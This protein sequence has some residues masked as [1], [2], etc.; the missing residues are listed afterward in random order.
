VKLVFEMKRLYTHT[1]KINVICKSTFRASMSNSIEL[2]FFVYTPL[3]ES[4]RN[5]MHSI[6]WTETNGGKQNNEHLEGSLRRLGISGLYYNLVSTELIIMQH[7]LIHL[8]I[9][10]FNCKTINFLF[11]MFMEQR[12]FKKYIFIHHIKLH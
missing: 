12:L 5:V 7:L 8:Y 1:H 11:F 6:S 2:N 4:D 9:F 10:L 3:N